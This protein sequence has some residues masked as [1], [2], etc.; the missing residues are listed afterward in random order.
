MQDFNNQYLGYFYCK[1]DL[2]TELANRET[3]PALP[4]FYTVAADDKFYD[5]LY[6]KSF[7]LDTYEEN[8]HYFNR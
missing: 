8:H 5:E 4:V 7:Y 3:I 1:K 6:R 2:I